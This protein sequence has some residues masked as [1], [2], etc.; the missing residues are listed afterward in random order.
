MKKQEFEKLIALAYN[1]PMLSE[2]IPRLKKSEIPKELAEL[3][4]EIKKCKKCPLHLTRTNAVP[5]EGPADASIMFIGE[6]PGAD[7]DAQGRP[8]V[9]KAGQ[10]LTQLLHAAGIQRTSV[11]ITNVVKCR[12]PGNRT[13]SVNEILACKPFLIKQIKLIKPKVI[14]TLGA[15]STKV[16]LQSSEGITKLRGRIY[17][18]K[19]FLIVPTFHPSSVLRNPSQ[20]NIVLSDLHLVKEALKR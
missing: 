19:N 5:G 16:I 3:N 11:Y 18:T 20:R 2:E 17:K 14:C 10:L 8:F 9:G 13:P 15:V 4:E 12:P 1:C 7:E 6:A